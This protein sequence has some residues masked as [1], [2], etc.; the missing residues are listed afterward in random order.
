MKSADPVKVS[1]P[2]K[3]HQA[4]GYLVTPEGAGSFPAV[5]AI[6]EWWGIVPHMFDVARR[7]AEAGYICLIPDLYEGHTAE[8]PNEARKLAMALDRKKATA[9]ISAAMQFLRESNNV[10]PKQIGLVGWCM[11]AALSLSTSALDD[12]VGATVCFYG[13]P[14]EASDTA[15]ISAPILGL[16]GELDAG[17]PVS[18]VQDFEKELTVNKVE[19]QIHIY[20]DAHHAFFNDSRPEAFHPKVSEDAWQRT[21]AW[22]AKHLN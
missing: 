19:H 9:E 14:L 11:G 10:N 22:F 7:F 12:Q 5:V 18:M 16:Y 2:S 13:R 8:E 4:Q 17:I 21:L 20:P 15:N 3:N 6:Q 1:F